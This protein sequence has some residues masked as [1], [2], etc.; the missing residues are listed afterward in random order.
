[1]VTK[2]RA[3]RNPVSR[4]DTRPAPATQPADH[5]QTAHT[6]PSRSPA[7]TAG[8][9]PGG[10]REQARAAVCT[11]GHHPVLIRAA[12]ELVESTSKAVLQERGQEIADRDDL[13]TLVK[14]A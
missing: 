13:P 10:A 12:K 8:L 5:W 2:V 7:S 4:T 11:A 3:D 6:R 14:R 9:A 1:M